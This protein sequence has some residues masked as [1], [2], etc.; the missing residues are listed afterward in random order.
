M[1]GLNF[2]SVHL[3]SFTLTNI[4]I[5]SPFLYFGC[6]VFQID[7][8]WYTTAKMRYWASSPAMYTKPSSHSF[9]GIKVVYFLYICELAIDIFFTIHQRL[10]LKMEFPCVHCDL[11]ST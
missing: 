1:G 7:W 3:L 2:C 9:P 10:K 5:E 8:P 4:A 11:K 6:T